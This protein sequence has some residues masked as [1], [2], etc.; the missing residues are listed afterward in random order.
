MS[1]RDN[2]G[3]LLLAAARAWQHWAGVERKGDA[4]LG[5]G[6]EAAVRKRQV[7]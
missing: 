5:G 1:H 2:L 4:N 3:P 6:G 7:D